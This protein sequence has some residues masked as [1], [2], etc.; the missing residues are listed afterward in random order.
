[1]FELINENLLLL[2]LLLKF[3]SLAFQKHARL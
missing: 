2:L 3:L 1:M